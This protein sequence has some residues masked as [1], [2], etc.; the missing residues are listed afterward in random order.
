MRLACLPLLT[1]AFTAPAFTAP[2][3]SQQYWLP[4]GPGGT[5]WNNPQGSFNGTVYEHMLQR[6]AQRLQWDRERRAASG[7]VPVA[8][9]GSDPSFALRNAGR[10]T[11]REVYVSASRD[12]AWG[13]DRLGRSVLAPGQSLV[14]RLP[15]GQCLNDLRIVTMDG[16]AQ[17]R[18]Q[19]NTCALT[20]L[21]VN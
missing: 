21:A 2:A 13:A 5:T 18:R 19:V 7:G 12:S 10:A 17:E 1:L 20:E 14:V 15:A 11:I 6:H 16:Q 3:M 8:A 4:N 9:R